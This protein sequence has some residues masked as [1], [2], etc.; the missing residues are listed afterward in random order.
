MLFFRDKHEELFLGN[1]SLCIYKC[2][3]WSTE[4]KINIEWNKPP[5]KHYLHIRVLLNVSKNT[6]NFKHTRS[7]I[8]DSWN[9]LQKFR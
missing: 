2:Q 4:N 9:E 1:I 5:R 3:Q 7:M 6:Q 8:V